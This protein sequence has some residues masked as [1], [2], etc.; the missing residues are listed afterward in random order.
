MKYKRSKVTTPLEGLPLT[1]V[2]LEDGKG[3]VESPWALRLPDNKGFVL[4]NH[5][6]AFAPWP[7]W[8]AIIPTD[9]LMFLPT[10]DKQELELHPEA[11]DKGVKSGMISPD[12]DGLEHLKWK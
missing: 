3:Y 4:Q 2:R 1:K 9:S 5:A 7:S 12:G 8:G 11:Y 6:I 10:I